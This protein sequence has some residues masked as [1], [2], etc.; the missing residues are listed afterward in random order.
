MQ[1]IHGATL[2][3]VEGQQNTLGTAPY[4]SPPLANAI[5]ES[6]ASVD[7]EQPIDGS[8]PESVPGEADPE[9]TE[10][11]IILDSVT[12]L[13]VFTGH[14]GPS[15]DV[16]E[17]NL[18]RGQHISFEE[19]A[20]AAEK[21]MRDIGDLKVD[22]ALRGYHGTY[23]VNRWLVCLQ[24]RLGEPE[25]ERWLLKLQRNGRQVDFGTGTSGVSWKHAL[26]L[27]SPTS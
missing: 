4:S 2:D 3:Q 8:A 19:Y 14:N 24:W 21:R 11:E 22:S 9:P 10:A 6:V 12:G 25:R 17:L 5:D 20:K 23:V 13:G 7:I 26:S 15:S 27:M 16:S 18:H 1:A